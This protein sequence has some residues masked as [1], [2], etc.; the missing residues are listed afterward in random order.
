MIR[1]TLAPLINFVSDGWLAEDL[2]P[3]DK[4]EMRD[5]TSIPWWEQLAPTLEGIASTLADHPMELMS[6]VG[7]CRVHILTRQ[8]H[9][10]G[11][12]REGR[13]D[14][15]SATL[16]LSN[17]DYKTDGGA[18]QIKKPRRNPI[19]RMPTLC[20]AIYGD[21]VV[22]PSQWEHRVTPLKKN[23]LRVTVAAIFQPVLL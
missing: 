12:H 13:P 17:L 5:R 9:D 15:L 4:P 7:G 16:F 6:G 19:A 20:P 1:L 2:K 8:S 3:G 11:W 21:L 22:F 10:F 14:T 18:L 23:V